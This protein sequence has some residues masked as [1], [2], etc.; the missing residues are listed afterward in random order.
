MEA[1]RGMRSATPRHLSGSKAARSPGSAGASKRRSG[2]D[3][4]PPRDQV[5][6]MQRARLLAAVVETVAAVGYTDMSVAQVIDRAGVSRRT[7]YELFESREDCFLAAFNE[8]VRDLGDS[9]I[10]A[11][12]QERTWLG[13]VRAGLATLIELLEREP[14]IAW[15]CLVESWKAGE[16]TLERRVALSGVLAAT[17][18]EGRSGSGGREPSP[19]TGE[20]LIGAV[21]SVLHAHL[22]LGKKGSLMELH[23]P[24]MSMIALPYLGPSAARGE[25][26][27]PAPRM[28]PAQ[29]SSSGPADRLLDGVTMRLTYRTLLVLRATEEQPGSN[30]SEI[31]AAAGITDQGQISKLLRRLED[32]GLLENRG[33][34]P[35]RGA[36][37]A[38]SL[39]ATGARMVNS[40]EAWRSKLPRDA[41]GHHS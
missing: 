1:R 7:F 28:E 8:A 25:L 41:R 12:E 23:G 33:A 13:G 15:L 9:V 31:A 26:R 34:G 27:R 32:L 18:D 17:L 39:T 4:V 10:K 14:A 21:A 11:F 20:G 2:A 5:S 35:E 38:W 36:P 16:Q 24:L 30:N 3:G 22:A 37:N 29:T 19:L 6:E 40:I